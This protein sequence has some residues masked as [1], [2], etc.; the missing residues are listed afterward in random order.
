MTNETA[1]INLRKQVREEFPAQVGTHDCV[2]QARGCIYHLTD[3][4]VIPVNMKELPA[5]RM[6]GLTSTQDAL[7]RMV[8]A[9]ELLSMGEFFHVQVHDEPFAAVFRD[10]GE[11]LA[12]DPAD[13]TPLHTQFITPAE[14]RRVTTEDLVSTAKVAD[15]LKRVGSP[16][17]LGEQGR[18][19]DALIF[20]DNMLSLIM[21]EQRKSDTPMETLR[22]TFWNSAAR[23]E[24][25][26]NVLIG[27]KLFS[28]VEAGSGAER[29]AFIAVSGEVL[30][31][32][33][34]LLERAPGF[35]PSELGL[36]AP[37]AGESRPAAPEA[38][39]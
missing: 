2:F 9:A 18:R 6:S 4:Q 33:Q 5:V 28:H 32:L 31:M 38:R 11:E 24:G 15:L 17:I 29:H 13:E 39:L 25:H 21:R 7:R 30:H 19:P 1:M 3:L 14:T 8:K 20:S 23:R 27:R 35:D 16:L 37:D 22:A 36:K 12:V 10:E 26:L 34:P